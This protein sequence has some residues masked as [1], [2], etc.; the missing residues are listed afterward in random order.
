MKQ[1]TFLLGFFALLIGCQSESLNI[2]ETPD[3]LFARSGPPVS[4]SSE[5]DPHNSGDGGGS[6]GEDFTQ[7]PF[8]NENFCEGFPNFI[9]ITNNYN[10]PLYVNITEVN[11]RNG[12]IV[13]NWFES[14]EYQDPTYNEFKLIEPRGKLD[15]YVSISNR[16]HLEME[17]VDF[18]ISLQYKYNLESSFQDNLDLIV[19]DLGICPNLSGS[20]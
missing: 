1:I 13:S 17:L 7:P 3:T 19:E 15:I 5:N 12:Y 9:R 6:S 16:P 18:D 14:Q 10:V 20:F 2:T 8:Y 4:G 11:A